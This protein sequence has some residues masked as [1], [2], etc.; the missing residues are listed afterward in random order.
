MPLTEDQER[1][2]KSKARRYKGGVAR[3]RELLKD[4]EIKCA[5][6]KVPVL[7]DSDSG[8]AKKGRGV[9]ACY[10]TIDHISPSTEEKGLQ[11]NLLCPKR[12]QRTSSPRLFRGSRKTKP[13]KGLM[14]R[15]RTQ[16]KK[17]P[18]DSKAFYKILKSDSESKKSS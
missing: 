3:F 12:S 14:K 16:A 18:L 10:A 2:C 6:S 8:T 7:F 15:W 5:L 9:H 17:K 13:W 4:G 11:S 1:W